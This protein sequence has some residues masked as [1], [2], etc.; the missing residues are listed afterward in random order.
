[1]AD[2]T[3]TLQKILQEQLNTYTELAQVIR[4]Q[5]QILTEGR[6]EDLST[7]LDNEIALIARGKYLE[8]ARIEFMWEMAELGRIPSDKLTLS[9]LIDHMG[10]GNSGTL[11]DIRARLRSAV[12]HLR[13]VNEQNAELLRVSLQALDNVTT[14]V[15]GPNSQSY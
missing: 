10:N 9:E 8:Q 11:M 15:F 6:I 12:D 14:S 13:E 1:M 3:D 2:I 5:Q 4:D 7:N